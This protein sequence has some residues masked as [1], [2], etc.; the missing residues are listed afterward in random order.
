MTLVNQFTDESVHVIVIQ[1]KID[2]VIFALINI[3]NSNG[4]IKQLCRPSD[5]SRLEQNVSNIAKKNVEMGGD[6]NFY[7]DSNLE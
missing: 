2:D 4:E 5:L 3:Y 6:F 7:S 1:S